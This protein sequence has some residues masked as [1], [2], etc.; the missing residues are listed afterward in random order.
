LG[1]LAATKSSQT[2]AFLLN[3]AGALMVFVYLL[4][5]VAHIRL[6]RER[7]RTGAPAPAIQ[8]WL[9]PWASYAAIA[10]MCAILVAMALTPSLSRDFY[11][12]L[13][14][15]TV[16]VVAYLVT[17]ALRSSAAPS[18]TAMSDTRS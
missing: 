14:S 16:A 1:I 15:L 5:A 17:R 9:F 7:E 10:G 11:V 18:T 3:S 2:F 4:T 12:S 13:I 8:M 6:R